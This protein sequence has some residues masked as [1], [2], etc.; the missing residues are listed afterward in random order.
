M[1]D[2][3]EKIIAIDQSYRD[4]STQISVQET[5]ARKAAFKI[6]EEIEAAGQRSVNELMAKTKSE[7]SGLRMAAQQET[8]AKIDSA[9]KKVASE[10]DRLADQMIASLLDQK[11]SLS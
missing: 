5:D 7:I 2:V 10:A 3:R 8:D 11:R 4:I 9:R 1:V 6:R